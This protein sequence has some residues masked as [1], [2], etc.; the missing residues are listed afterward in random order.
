MATLL[1]ELN[2]WSKNKGEPFMD[3]ISRMDKEVSSIANDGRLLKFSVADGYAFYEVI[4]INPPKLRHIP[5]GDNW[6]ISDAHIRGLR[7]ADIQHL[8]EG[9]KLMRELFSKKA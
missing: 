4:S 2:S 1:P 6:G 7:A 9:E 5:A 8:L 3:Y